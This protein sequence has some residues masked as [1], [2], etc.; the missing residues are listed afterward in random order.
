MT[1]AVGFVLQFLKHLHM[2][3]LLILTVLNIDV[4]H[5]SYRIPTKNKIKHIIKLYIMNSII[6]KNLYEV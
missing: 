3:V 6:I 5:T 2:P 4:W 1:I